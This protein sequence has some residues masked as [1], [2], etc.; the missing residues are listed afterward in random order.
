[1]AAN[2]ENITW[3]AEKAAAN[4]L[5]EARIIRIR[6][7][8][9]KRKFAEQIPDSKLRQD[10]K[11]GNLRRE[12]RSLKLKGTDI[13]GA[14]SE[15]AVAGTFLQEKEVYYECKRFS[16]LH[17]SPLRHSSRFESH[18]VDRGH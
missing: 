15:A 8:R 18:G 4:R 10:L 7:I 5:G 6:N 3:V 13:A 2:I 14:Q 12:A 11:S 1:M 17:P 9:H 16:G